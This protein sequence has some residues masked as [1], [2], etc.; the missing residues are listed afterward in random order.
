MNFNNNRMRKLFMI[1]CAVSLL[2]FCSIKAVAQNKRF[3]AEKVECK[4][5]FKGSKLVLIYK[6]DTMTKKSFTYNYDLDDFIN[7]DDSSKLILIE[8]LLKFE[9]DTVRCCLDATNWSFNGIEGCRGKPKGVKYY[10]IQIDALFMINR[11]CWPK[12]MELYSC[13]QVLYDNK[14]KK[15]I[16]SDQ[17]KIKIVFTAYKKWFEVCKAKGK[18][19]RY[20]PFNDGQYVWYGGRKSI[21]PRN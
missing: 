19:E 4:N 15:D 8:A 16:N 21:I 6:R 1:F 5:R 18:I 17:K 3:Y 12:L 13:S 11:L 2:F 10:S 20:F 14:L 7:L 9:D